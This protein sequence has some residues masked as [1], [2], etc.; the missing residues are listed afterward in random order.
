MG[1][2]TVSLA[3]LTLINFSIVKTRARLVSESQESHFIARCHS[4]ACTCA[5]PPP[6][7][8]LSSNLR[9]AARGG[10]YQGCVRISSST[11]RYVLVGTPDQSEWQ[12]ER[13]CANPFYPLR[14]E[15]Q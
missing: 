7:P 6:G 11:P 14:R 4:F 5:P 12:A 1:L 3:M 10:L 9:P 8:Y 13:C 2:M 15:F